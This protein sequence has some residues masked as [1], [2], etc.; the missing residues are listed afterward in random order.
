MRGIKLRKSV[1]L[2]VVLAVICLLVAVVIVLAFSALSLVGQINGPK[3][4]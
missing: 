4:K 3:S 1:E 2:L